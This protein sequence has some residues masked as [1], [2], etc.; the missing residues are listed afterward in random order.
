MSSRVG[1]CC[2]VLFSFVG[3]QSAPKRYADVLEGQWRAKAL[4]KD[5]EEARSYIVNL[6][7]NLVRNQRARMDVSTALGTGVASLVVDEREVRYILADSKR[8]YIGAAQANVMRPILSIPFDPRWLN[9]ILLEEP[10]QESGWTCARDSAGFLKQCQEARMGL[11]VTWS[12]RHGEKKTVLL[13]H[14]KASVQIKVQS[15]KP[16]V[17]ERKNLFVLEPPEGYKKL[18]LR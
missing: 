6:N 2:L 10:I 5:L 17:E 12:E 1:I 15:F 3:C 4:V 14:S 8:F 13:E 18:N 9:N 16:K 11:K 7:I